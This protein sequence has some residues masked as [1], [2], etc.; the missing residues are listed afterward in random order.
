MRILLTGAS[1]FMGRRLLPVLSEH[2]VVCLTTDAGFT[3]NDHNARPLV[4]DLTKAGQWTTEVERFAPQWCIHL[5]WEGLPDYSL[6]R[7]RINLDAG[8][9]LFDLLARSGVKRIVVSGSCWEYG[10]AT[11]PVGENQPAID[12]GLFAST[13]Q[14]LRVMLES[15]SRST[16][17]ESRWARIFFAYGPG[18]RSN[19]LI[20]HCYA[21]YESGTEPDVRNP[22]LMQDFVYA[23]DVA[24]GLKAVAECDGGS[25]IFN[26]G[27]GRPTTVAEVVNCVARHFDQVFPIEAVEPASGFWAD[28]TAIESVT[29]WKAQTSIDDGISRTI[30]ALKCQ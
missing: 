21:A 13:K 27:S 5:A 15:I 17:I 28:T 6:A 8:V 7:C 4:G 3:V 26:I 23:D 16:G 10:N 9:G 12:C 30:K 2:E 25:G 24:T 20:P 18:Q 11:G 14:A 1:G 22:A 19:S 29:G